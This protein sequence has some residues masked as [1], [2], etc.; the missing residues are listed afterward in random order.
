MFR[1]FRTFQL[2]DGIPKVLESDGSSGRTRTNNPPVNSRISSNG[3]HV[4]AMT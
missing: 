2:K 3:V 1:L 4:F